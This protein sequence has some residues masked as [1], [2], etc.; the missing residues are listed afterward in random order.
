MP[1]VKARR[2][3]AQTQKYDE[4]GGFDVSKGGF[5]LLPSQRRRLCSQRPVLQSMYTNRPNNELAVALVWRKGI[6]LKENEKRSKLLREGRV[7]G[8]AAAIK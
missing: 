3:T 4:A 8:E 2:S 6:G 1:T 7:Y 5:A